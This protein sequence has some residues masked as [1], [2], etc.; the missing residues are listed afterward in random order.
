MI[1]P[2]PKIIWVMILSLVS[3]VS[4][5]KLGTA[6]ATVGNNSWKN[7][8]GSSTK[9]NSEKQNSKVIHVPSYLVLQ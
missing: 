9:D 7:V 3:W 2:N 5:K 6:G 1:I 8:R 4:I